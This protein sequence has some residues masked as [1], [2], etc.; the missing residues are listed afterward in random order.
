MNQNEVENEL[1][2]WGIL[3]M[4]WG[5]RRY[6]N[7]DGSLTPEGRERYSKQLKKS[8]EKENK[9]GGKVV[10]SVYEEFNKKLPELNEIAEKRNLL[11]SDPNK[12]MNGDSKYLKFMDSEFKKVFKEIASKEYGEIANKIYDNEEEWLSE[13]LYYHSMEDD[14]MQRVYEYQ[15][16]HSDDSDEDTLKHWGILGM[17]WGIRNYQNPDGSLTP[18]GRIRYGVGAKKDITGNISGI[19]DANS[20]SDEELKRMTKRYQSQADYYQA[21]NNYINQERYFKNNIATPKKERKES[22]VGRFMKNVFGAPLEQFLA[23]NVQFGLGAI[24]Y[25]ILNG[26]GRSELAAQYL[27]SVTGM[28]MPYKK[29]DAVKDATDEARKQ[30]DYWKTLNDLEKNKRE[31]EDI[32]NGS[33]DEQKKRQDELNEYQ[34]QNKY[35]KAKFTYESNRAREESERR[36]KDQNEGFIIDFDKNANEYVYKFF[37]PDFDFKEKDNQ[38]FNFDEFEFFKEAYPEQNERRPKKR[39]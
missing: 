6:Q 19:N 25:N 5:I 12:N 10:N 9:Y 8:I 38:G 21:R 20:L 34:F 16:N 33:Y 39:K 30:A 15:M 23:K 37:D 17:K 7:P 11:S 29:K 36:K 35:D 22:G 4:H 13:F 18:L 26:E 14:Y 1:K 27:N 2:H 28:N 31:H 32:K 24:G 3:G